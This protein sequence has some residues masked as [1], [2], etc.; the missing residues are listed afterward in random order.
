MSASSRTTIGTIGDR[1]RLCG[2][3]AAWY[4]TVLISVPVRMLYHMRAEHEKCWFCL[5]NQLYNSVV[6]FWLH[7][8][9]CRIRF[10]Y[11]ILFTRFW[12]HNQVHTIL[13]VRFC[14]ILFK[15]KI[16]L[17]KFVCTIL[18]ARFS[19][20]DSVCTILFAQFCSHDSVR[21]ILFARFCSHNSVHH[22]MIYCVESCSDVLLL[23][24][25]TA[26][27]IA[28]CSHLSGIKKCRFKVHSRSIAKF[29]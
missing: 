28:F 21:T 24:K 2:R 13:V 3:Y 7:D 23:P 4:H 26:T 27:M 19:L 25:Q 17:Y 22:C 8:F 16:A 1:S 18:F 14:A 12:W 9:D 15:C 5:R 29:R 11:A 6:E 10:T 20:H